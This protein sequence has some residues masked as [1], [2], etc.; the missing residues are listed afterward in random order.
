MNTAFTKNANEEVI[1]RKNASR[2]LG[3]DERTITRWVDSGILKAWKTA[4]GHNRISK[5][6]VDDLLLKRKKEAEDSENQNRL[7]I[8]VVEDDSVLLEFY[9]SAI[10][11]WELPVYLRTAKDGVDG[12]LKMGRKKPDIIITDLKMPGM[13]GF[14]MIRKLKSNPEFSDIKILA[15]TALESNEI[16]KRGGLPDDVHVFLKPAPMDQ[17]KQ[18]LTKRY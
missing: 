8:L 2:L 5:K 16:D 12:L 15:I 13:D 18:L 11:S 6:S 17:L 9:I 3:V 14:H 4:G 7:N 1:G 10:E